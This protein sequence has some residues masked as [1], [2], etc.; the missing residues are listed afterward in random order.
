MCITE[1]DADLCFPGN[2]R[3]DNHLC[4]RSPLLPRRN[5]RPLG[6]VSTHLP[7]NIHMGVSEAHYYNTTY[8]L[9]GGIKYTDLNLFI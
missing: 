7:C 2:C 5:P 9:H 6:A 3:H 8:F 4:C 1:Q